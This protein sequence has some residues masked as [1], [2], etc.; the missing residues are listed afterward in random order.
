MHDLSVNRQWLAGANVVVAGFCL[1]GE[2]HIAQVLPDFY[3]AYLRATTEPALLLYQD[4]V[5]S[6]I[7]LGPMAFDSIKTWLGLVDP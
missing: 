5:L 2:A 1:G 7:H 4:G 6:T 3:E